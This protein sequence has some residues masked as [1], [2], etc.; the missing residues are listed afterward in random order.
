MWLEER[1][2]IF[3][4]RLFCSS[5]ANSICIVSD[6]TNLTKFVSIF[7][8]NRLNARIGVVCIVY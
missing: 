8:L 3:S 5:I 4:E 2:Y 1:D 7:Y 6:K